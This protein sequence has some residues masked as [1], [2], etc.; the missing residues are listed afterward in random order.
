[1]STDVLH[2]ENGKRQYESEALLTYLALSL[3]MTAVTLGTWY[4]LYYCVK[5]KEALLPLGFTYQKNFNSLRR[6]VGV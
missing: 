1:M 2:W 5:R 3:P 4:W 6:S